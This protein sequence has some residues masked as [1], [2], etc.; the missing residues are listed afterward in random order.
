MERITDA[1]IERF[2]AFSD[3]RRESFDNH[4]E[5]V[6]TEYETEQE[7]RKVLSYG[8]RG[9][10]RLR[11]V[12]SL[13]VAEGCSLPEEKALD[14]AAITE[15]IHNATL[16]VDDYADDTNARRGVPTLWRIIESI[17]YVSPDSLNPRTYTILAENGLLAI[18]L[19]L[20][21]DPDVVDVMG[22]TVQQ[23]FKGFYLEGSTIVDG[24]FGEGYDTYMEI[25]RYKT[26]GLFGLACLLPIVGG[27]F[28]DAQVAAARRYGEATGILYQVVDD[29]CDGDLPRFIDDPHQELIVW[30]RKAIAQVS[31]MP[32][33]DPDQRRL[34]E[35]APAWCA[36]K[37]LE[38]QPTNDLAPTFS[39]DIPNLEEIRRVTSH[40]ILGSI[41]TEVT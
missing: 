36:T 19:R 20:A 35:L 34:L 40:N 21:D 4:L 15:L 12:L 22:E 14:Y 27:N 5:E 9:G 38:N 37:M 29:Y 11:P 31:D 25:N 3:E 8:V 6:I 13:T 24:L 10:K 2:D 17:P 7:L 1:D 39:T 30:Y 33:R 26:G 16:I 32:V 41:E 28:D 18:A 23:V